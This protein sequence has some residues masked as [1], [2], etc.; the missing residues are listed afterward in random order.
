[1]EKLGKAIHPPGRKL[2]LDRGRTH[3]LLGEW[4]ERSHLSM[5]SGLQHWP[6]RSGKLSK[7]PLKEGCRDEEHGRAVRDSW[8][9]SP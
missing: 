5:G 1:M 7:G 8:E 9:G 4:V 2:T 6:V 3:K